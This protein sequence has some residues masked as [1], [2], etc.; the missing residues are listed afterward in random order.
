MSAAPASDVLLV[1]GGLANGLLAWRLRQARPELRLRL[2]ERDSTLGGEH[3]WSYH[4]ADVTA[5]Q[6]EWLAPLVE[7]RWAGY[8]VRFPGL[9]RRLGSGYRS[10]TA[11]RLH[12]RVRAVLGD[13]AHLGRAVRAVDPGG[14]T[15][16]DGTRLEARCVVDGRGFVQGDWLRAGVQEF[17]GL[18]VTLA[19]DH[20]LDAPVLMDATVPQ[21]GGFRFFYLLPW[22]ERRLLIEETRYADAASLRPA[23]ARE[24]IERY[25][26]GRGWRI[27]SVDREERGALPIP[28][29]GDVEALW[30]RLPEGVAASGMRAGLFHATTGYSLPDAVRLADRVAGL[31]TLESRALAAQVRAVARESWRRQAFLR[32]LNRMLFLAAAPERRF[33]VLARFY[34]LGPGL[35]ERFYAGRLTWLDRVRLLTGRPPVPVGRALRCL[36]PR[37]GERSR[38]GA[39]ASGAG[40]DEGSKESEGRA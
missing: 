12:E 15:L 36:L 14:A 9:A 7:R 6:H 1:G 24:A 25:A 27:V 3:T 34:R 35:I 37:A 30:R 19:E 29:A 33:M 39:G 38:P 17:V 2:V 26:A 23:E 5:S 18:D 16:E 21:D 10:I 11:R 8:D 13:A 28:L 4:D 22:S 20:G 31:G 32:F 40:R